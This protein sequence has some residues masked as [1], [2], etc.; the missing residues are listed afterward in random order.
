MTDIV[1][2]GE[3][4]KRRRKLLDLTRNGLAERVGCSPVTINKIERD[5]R[6]PSVEIAELLA[7]HLQIPPD[8]QEEFIQRARG[9]Y[10]AHFESPLSMG[11]TPTKAFPTI[12]QSPNYSQINQSIEVE[13]P[14]IGRE[15]EWAKL[16]DIWQNLT[17]SHLVCISGEAGIGKTRLAEELQMEAEKGAFGVSHTRC[18]S[19]EGQ[20]AYGPIVDWL[21]T[22][23]VQSR[24]PQI[25]AKRKS[26][27]ARLL[28]ELL[29][30]DPTLEHPKPISQDVQRKHF[31][32]AL[33]EVFLGDGKRPLLLVLDDLQW[34]DKETLEWLQY[35]LERA[36][37][38][39]LIVGTVRLDEIGVEHPLHHLIQQ[40][41]RTDQVTQI[42]LAPLKQSDI[43]ALVK[44]VDAQTAS[45]QNSES[46]FDNT[47]GNPLFAIES[48]RAI[49]GQ[50]NKMLQTFVKGDGE[51]L[52]Q[53][54]VAIPPKMY[55]II[56]SR[57][58]QLPALALQMA[59]L[60]AVIGRIFDVDL[61]IT[62][63][64]KDE[65]DVYSAVDALWQRKLIRQI[66]GA[67][68][69]F[70]HDRIR[71]VAYAEIS[72]VKKLQLHRRVAEGIEVHY[73][74]HLNPYFGEIAVHCEQAGL[75]QKAFSHYEKAADEA[76]KIYSSENS[77]YFRKKSIDIFQKLPK[78][79][80]NDEKLFYLLIEAGWDLQRIYGLGEKR[81]GETWQKAYEVAK[82]NGDPKLKFEALMR[83][84]NQNRLNGYW[85]ES[86]DLVSK[87]LS[88]PQN[89]IDPS[90]SDYLKASVA[91]N[92]LH[93][94]RLQIALLN[95]E[96]VRT[97]YK[98]RNEPFAI[99]PYGHCLWLSGYP[100]NAVSVTKSIM[101][102]ANHDPINHL[103][104]AAQYMN[105][106]NMT[107]AFCRDVSKVKALSLQ[108]I[109]TCKYQNHPFF[110]RFGRI[111]YG[112]SL[113]QDGDFNQGI[114]LIQDNVEALK[115]HGNL[116]FDQFRRALLIDAYL[117]ANES[118][119]ALDEIEK[120]LAF[121]SERGNVY[122]DGWLYTLQG[123]ALEK[124]R[125][126]V[127]EVEKC[128]LQAIEITRQQ[129]ARSLE[130]RASIPLAELWHSQGRVVEAYQL[131]SGIYNW[132][133]EG[134]DTADLKLAKQLLDQWQPA[135]P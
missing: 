20:L 36:V 32:D 91:H 105:L 65:D 67:R 86:S 30:A 80:E 52:E 81:S 121:S 124:L 110:L 85:H 98:M 92:H 97:A 26:E 60:G 35:L 16:R 14:L 1:S 69:D 133:T 82:R 5:E 93:L 45:Q 96:E 112:W 68:F 56:R 44:Q 79:N 64:K 135:I 39:L 33:N 57:F 61:L 77:L 40:L 50:S 78:K 43:S 17:L 73:A 83:L 104:S 101:D 72:K 59:Q 126:P 134:F 34:C 21:R 102:Q 114:P 125:Y 22:S 25:G 111:Y 66:D 11:T 19:L 113:S 28:P 74:N 119:Y 76:R 47:G 49:K 89:G 63:S 131:L 71:D 95:F 90:K 117:V 132:F 29:E 18:H 100:E 38:P 123:S 118:E 7:E 88:L 42:N 31:F 27:V 53:N 12:K 54:Q 127:E 37:Q 115:A 116:V 128:Y 75:F 24:L 2:F 109:E 3:W 120:L 122:L 15:L 46:F 94:G 6:R 106:H 87:A 51:L 13:Y 130:L 58:S 62:A 48:V 99:F 129:K 8:Q 108:Q 9:T 70:S 55:A 103:T 4:V 23:T 41:E 107:L 84:S 10:V